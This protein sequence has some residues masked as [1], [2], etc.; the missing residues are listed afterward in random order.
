MAR[1]RGLA[2]NG[3]MKRFFSLVAVVVLLMPVMVNPVTVRAQDNAVTADTGQ[4]PAPG[5]T[6]SIVPD[7]PPV[8]TAA[9][10]LAGNDGEISATPQ[11]FNVINHAPY[12]VTGSFVTNTYVN[13]GGVT[14]RHRANFRLGTGEQTNFCS[15]GPFYEGGRLELVLR[16]L[17]PIFSCKTRIDGD[18][19]INGRKKPEGGTD[20]WAVCR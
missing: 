2:Y 5:S 15:Q 14:A 8:P 19:V 11:C 7:L 3:G 1:G 9:Q 16:T 6:P 18:I 4:D 12:T 13:D 20:T 17:V 10:P